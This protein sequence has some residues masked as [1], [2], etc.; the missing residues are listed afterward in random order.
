MAT[1]AVWILV[2]S[3]VMVWHRMFCILVL[4]ELDSKSTCTTSGQSSERVVDARKRSAAFGSG[5]C[6]EAVVV[7]GKRKAKGLSKNR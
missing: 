1:I 2:V 3:I 6:E 4:G 5:F 7:V